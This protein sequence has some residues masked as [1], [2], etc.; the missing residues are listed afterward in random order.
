MPVLLTIC[1]LYTKIWL[2]WPTRKLSLCSKSN[3]L[4][5][6]NIFSIKMISLYWDFSFMVCT[7][8]VCSLSVPVISAKINIVRI[9]HQREVWLINC[10][11]LC[12]CW[13]D[14]DPIL[15]ELMTYRYADTGWIGN[16]YFH[17]SNRHISNKYNG[18]RT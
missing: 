14:S 1:L 8:Y 13:W 5:E 11:G 9:D 10:G 17:F 4:L 2:D 15:W 6:I 7:N 3:K 18:N 16:I 12:L